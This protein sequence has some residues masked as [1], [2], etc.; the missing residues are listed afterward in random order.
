[1]FVILVMNC[2]HEVEYSGHMYGHRRQ[3]R[4]GRYTFVRATM[5]PGWICH[6]CRCIITRLYNIVQNYTTYSNMPPMCV[7]C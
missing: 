7:L 3:T 2:M 5:Q 6:C 1:M 4:E